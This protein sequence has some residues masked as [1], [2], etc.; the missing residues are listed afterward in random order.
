MAQGSFLEFE[1]AEHLDAA[2]SS[3]KIICFLEKHGL[4]YKKTLV[5]QGYDG[6]TVMHGAHTGVQAKIKE[7]DKYAFYVHCSAHCLNLVIIDAV[8]SVADAGNFFSLCIHVWVL[9]A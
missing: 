3:D 7:V 4:E 6:V 1:V 8:K 5:G 2:A 9:C